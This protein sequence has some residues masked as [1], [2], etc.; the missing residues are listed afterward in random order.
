MQLARAV[1]TDGESASLVRQFGDGFRRTGVGSNVVFAFLV[2]IAS[3]LIL[4]VSQ[5]ALARWMGDFEYGIYVVVWTWVLLL[6]GLSTLG[7]STAM[8]RLLPEQRERGAFDLMRGLLL[9]GR[10][11]PVV[12]SAAVAI[13][14][15]AGL[16][17][18]GSA[19]D[20]HYLLPAYLALVCLPLV[21]LTDLQDGIGRANGWV[22]VALLPPYVVRPLVILAAMIGAHEAGLDMSAATAVAAAIVAASVAAI[23]QTLFLGHRLRSAI[24]RGPRAIA[25]GPW[26]KMSLPLLLITGCEVLMQTIDVLVISHYLPPSD[27]A[28]YFAATKTMSVVLFVHFAVGS[29]FANRFASLSA[30]GDQHAL[31]GTIRQAVNWTFWPSLAVAVAILALGRPVLW[32]FG[33]QFTAGYGLMAILAVGYLAK[34]ATGP[35]EFVL[36]MLG[37]QKACAAG[38]AAT[39]AL[40]LMLCVL[41]V[42]S[43]GPVG[44]AIAT[45]TAWTANAAL[46]TLLA[47]RHLGIDIAIWS[48]L[49]LLPIR[50]GMQ[51]PA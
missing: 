34:A 2:R 6:G 30:R 24:P 31:K 32:L 10:V 43:F 4:Y 48:N 16:R 49:P 46:N 13:A 35:S 50:R 23:A 14:G 17:L 28:I 15:L 40:N 38:L 5:I 33:P 12:F 42:P 26:F 27:I 7:L 37:Q 21:T 1:T 18:F 39:V 29:A 22:G 36:N 44:A 3:A 25:L 8:M 9:G 41:L 19:M 51:Q 45:A 47:R 20:S 11:V